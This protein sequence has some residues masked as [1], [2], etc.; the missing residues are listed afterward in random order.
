[1]TDKD[2]HTQ[3]N[4]TDRKA[5]AIT[6]SQGAAGLPQ[7]TAKGSGYLAERILQ[8]AFDHD[9]KVRQDKALTDI[10]AAYDIESPVPLEALGAVSEILDYVYQAN[11][12]AKRQRENSRQDT[13]TLEATE[14][15]DII[16]L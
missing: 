10:L 14:K 8:I 6:D 4:I 3:N 12:K 11:L 16:D 5:V 15:P 1:M 13:V 9:I 2:I 7:I